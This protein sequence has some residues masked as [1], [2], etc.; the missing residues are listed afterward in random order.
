MP[1]IAT[2]RL[3]WTGIVVFGT[4][5]P[6]ISP[7]C[8]WR[9]G[10]GGHPAVMGGQGV[11]V[12]LLSW[13]ARVWRAEVEID[14]SKFGKREFNRGLVVDGHWVFGGMERTTGDCFL[15]EVEHKDAATLLPIIQQFVRPGSIV[16]CDKWSSYRSLNRSNSEGG[17]SNLQ[18]YRESFPV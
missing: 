1:C 13:E 7:F 11:E 9:P 10:W 8:H 12:T 17:V 4:Y 15:V 16:Y 5:V 14:E 18:Y 3:L 2:C 6:S